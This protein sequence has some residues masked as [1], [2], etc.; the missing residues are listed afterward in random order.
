MKSN[1]YCSK[2]NN[3]MVLVILTVSVLVSLSVGQVFGQSN[4]VPDDDVIRVDADVTNLFFTVTDKEKRFVTTL[5]QNDL[6]IL[7]D[8]SPQEILTF[9]RATNRPV[10]IAFLID[11]SA[12]EARTLPD[13]KAATR[14]FIESMIRS[15]EDEVAIIPFADRAFLEQPFT[16]NLLRLYRVLTQI[17]IAL[18]LY[19]GSGPPIS[20]IA[21]GLEGPIP[22]TTAIWDAVFVTATELMASRSAHRRRAIIL[23]TDGRDTA[24]RVKRSAAIE[25]ALASE[26][27][28]YAIGI[29]DEK[30]EGVDRGAIQKLAEATGGRAFFPRKE[31][32]LNG[33]FAEIEREMRSQYLL[34][35]SSSNKNRDGAFRQMRI[36]VT[37]PTL[38]KQ[39]KLR[40]RPG[41]FAKPLTPE[42][43]Q[44]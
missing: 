36:E 23:L 4:R 39:L 10:S 15:R 29:G 24:S 14:S 25:R 44:R 28:I 8:G 16:D 18:P 31:P 17:E 34:A 1:L 42:S 12:S 6:E 26:T 41:Y 27:V 43:V 7:E 32:D 35:Y 38:R 2:A 11:V 19:T 40:H 9:Q 21:S 22:G 20:G 30:F 33:A 5:Q 37:N 13:E 3:Q